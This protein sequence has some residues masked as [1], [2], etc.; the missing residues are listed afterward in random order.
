MHIFY[1]FPGI[2]VILKETL[3]FDFFF[4]KFEECIYFYYFTSFS[5]I[6]ARSH[7]K[8]E[9][10]LRF[11]FTF[12][13]LNLLY[14]MTKFLK[15]LFVLF[16]F[17]LLLFLWVKQNVTKEEGCLRVCL[18]SRYIYYDTNTQTIYTYVC[19]CICYKQCFKNYLKCNKIIVTW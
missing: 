1:L 6:E 8:K 3:P 7:K 18:F 16:F 17:F 2:T 5:L 10:C 11:C 12:L 4:V 13:L 15:L 9:D 14:R 19:L